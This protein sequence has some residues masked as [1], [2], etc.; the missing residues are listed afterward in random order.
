MPPVAL[1]NLYTLPAD[2]FD[3]LGTEGVQLRLDDHNEATGQDI[4]VA[5]GGV[6]GD[7]TLQITALQFPLLAGST[8]E[9]DGGGAAAVVEVIWTAT[10]GVG[11]TSLTVQPLPAILPALAAARDSGVNLATAARLVKACKYGTSQC[12]LYLCSRYD[13]SALAQSWSVNRWATALAA[14][15]LCRRRGQAPPKGIADDAEEA[16]EEMR[17]VRVGMLQVEDIA[18]RTAAWPFIS[19]VTVDPRYD[20]ARVRVQTPLSEATPTQYSQYIDWNSA[21]GFFDW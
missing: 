8:L 3:Y 18:T 5:I 17:Q 14:R 15:W 10:A 21:L 20:F 11:A 4:A 1:A 12:K 7:T 9:F 6:L 19:N 16:L 2:L 13:D